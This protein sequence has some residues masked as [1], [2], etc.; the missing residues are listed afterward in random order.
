MPTLA[1]ATTPLSTTQT[2]HITRMADVLTTTTEW[3]YGCSTTEQEGLLGYLRQTCRGN[4]S[5]PVAQFSSA[6]IT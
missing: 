3:L 2:P 6:A 1:L 4:K 5:F